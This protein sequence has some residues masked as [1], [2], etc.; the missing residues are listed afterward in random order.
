MS[1]KNGGLHRFVHGGAMPAAPRHP[2]AAFYI[3]NEEGVEPR[4]I[5][6]FVLNLKSDELEM[7]ETEGLR[8]AENFGLFRLMFELKT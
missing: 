7:R 2:A 5:R 1:G 3:Q 4:A 8:L 6:F